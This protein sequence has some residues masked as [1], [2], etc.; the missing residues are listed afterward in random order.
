MSPKVHESP[1]DFEAI[2]PLVN[3]I[4]ILGGLNDQQLRSIVARMDEASYASGT[5]IFEQGQSPSH[6]FVIRRGRVRIVANIDSE[7]LEL[8][9]YGQ[10]QCFGETSAIGIE[11]HSATAVAVEPTD[12]LLLSAQAL[13]DLYKTDPP[14]FGMLILNIAREACRRLHR[15]GETFLH[16]AMAHRHPEV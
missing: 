5:R 13:H 16:Y 14:L 7:P 2:R 6:I 9:E 3:A 15:T 8:V 1:P 12:L 4:S 10:G 11:P